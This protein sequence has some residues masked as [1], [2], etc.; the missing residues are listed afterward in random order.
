MMERAEIEKLIPHRPP[1][2]WID[3][4]EELE[5]G[6]RCV[7]I[8]SL[9]PG[10]PVFSGHFPARPVLP[11]VLM[12]EAMA[13]TTAVMLASAGGDQAEAFNLLAAVHRFKFFK[14]VL[15]GERLRIETRKQTQ[16]GSLASIEGLLSVE[17]EK[18]ASGE[19]SVVLNPA[20]RR[21]NP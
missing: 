14:P 3:R 9:E 15:P 5:P 17:G 7:A 12:I 13:Q 20:P 10:N 4:V 2:L 19:L 16:S 11:G 6:V 21:E 8:L 1:F 18:V